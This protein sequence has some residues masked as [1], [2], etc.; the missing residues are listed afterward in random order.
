MGGSL[1]TAAGAILSPGADDGSAAGT[2]TA[3]SLALTSPTLRFDL[4]NNPAAGNDRLQATGAVSLNGPQNF[5]FNLTAGTLAPG[6]YEL[7][8]TPGT[9]TAT[10]VT[11]TSNL[12]TGS[13]QSLTLEHSPTGTAP[14]YVRLVVS[15]TN[16]DLTWTGTNGG[17]W[18]Q[19]TT[20]AWTGAS[21]ATFFNFDN[22]TFNDTATNG[23]VTITQPVA[24]QNLTVT[25]TAA[26]PYTFTGAP[27]TGSTSLIKSGTGSLTL[28]LP[29]YD[30]IDCS[31]TTGSPTVTVSST[32]GMVPGMTVISR[33]NPALIPAGTTIVS[34]VNATT[35][36]LSQNATATSTTARIIF[37]TR[38]TFS[39][40][41]ILNDGSLTLASNSWEYYSSA[42]PPPSNPFGLGTGP[43]TLNGGTLTLLGHSVSTLHVSG[44][45][46]NDLIVPAGKTATLRSVMRGTYLNDIAGLRG[47]LTGSGTL[48]LVVN[49]AY[50]AITGDWSAFS[51]TLNVT[52]PASGANDPRFQLGNDPGLP[53]A[54]VNLD[55]VTL[56]YTATPPTEGV[57][58]PIGSLS[59]TGNATTLIA[60]AET[61]FAP[62][63]WQVGA[64][65]T[66]TIFAGNFTPYGNAPVGLEKTGTGTWTLTGTGTVSAGITVD[67]G[68]LSYGDASTD[69]L[70]GT[71]E[72][73]IDP[74]AT[75]QLN[76]GAKI[77]GAACEIFTGGTLRGFGT[78]QAPVVSS[79]TLSVIGG[80]LSLTGDAD[81]AGILEFSSFSDRLAVTGNLNL[82]GS[83][84]LPTSGV[85]A[86]RKLLATY[87]GTLTL[88]S[89][90]LQNIPANYQ[91][92]LDTATP[93]EIAVVLQ[94]QSLYQAWQL[95]HFT[96]LD[97]PDGQ[98]AADPDNDGMI[99]QEE[100]EAGT[101]PKSDASFIP[102]VWQGG[103]TNPWDL[104]TTATWLENTTPRVFRD[105][106]QVTISDTG[107][108]SPAIN[109][110][111]TL[112]PGSLAVTNSTKAFTLSGTGSLA[113]TTGLV[114]SGTATLTLA[115]ANTYSGPTAIDAGVVTLQHATALGSATGGT[116]VAN[117]ARLELEGNITV[118][119]E[120]LIPRRH[121]RSLLLQRSHQLEI[122]HQHLDR[123][124]H[125]RPPAAPA[126]AP[127]P[128]PP[129]SSPAPSPAP[130]AS[131]S[132]PMT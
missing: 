83:L 29:R 72:I 39:G 70:A 111:G 105:K 120:S 69:T 114:K 5:I 116:T 22:V 26:R 60:G 130:P 53:L 33:D 132:A 127:R 125:P 112:A 97:N 86:G 121:R 129:S 17:L 50:S 73:S 81:L 89:V 76:S 55:Q 4:S 54:N 101:D 18:D 113:G 100:F 19:Q 13:R 23:S 78:L 106:R 115:T 44:A 27:I 123:P 104:A 102:L 94:D 93:G 64:L 10:G 91:A 87:T 74:A 84:K 108:N 119:G 99:N 45:L 52:R 36:T 9:L 56:T 61:G 28:S 107:S 79:G 8:T 66:S 47:N 38:N 14:G 126:S 42:F 37:E 131:P 58:I 57:V 110:I 77:I 68:T 65:N 2:F 85:T 1:T 51:G 35:V 62:V 98:P 63:T 7:I 16:A 24:P 48:N 6:T 31:I 21:P 41:T 20:T 12:P 80:T 88:G 40:G 95:I 59:G 124:R 122:R 109:L 128:E 71:S 25:N 3:A 32:T 46:P 30:L 103:G 96:T 15:G 92:T 67:Q 43:I 117:N 82:A 75:L 34:V 118:A 49:F 90:T 11:L